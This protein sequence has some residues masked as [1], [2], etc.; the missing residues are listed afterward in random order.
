[1]C[2][3][4]GYRRH[5]DDSRDLAAVTREPLR[6][7]V[8]PDEVIKLDGGDIAPLVTASEKVRD[9]DAQPNL[10]QMPGNMGAD[11]AGAAGDDDQVVAGQALHL[12]HGRPFK[13]GPRPM[14]L[15]AAICRYG[16]SSL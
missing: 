9:H 5:V 4:R 1:G 15:Y 6:Q 13:A 7:H 14:A 3:R 16:A 11:K 2:G 10:G 12:R 8:G